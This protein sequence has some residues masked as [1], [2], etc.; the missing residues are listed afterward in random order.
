MASLVS[1]LETEFTPAVGDFII[2]VTGV[3]ATLL[4]KNSS[5]TAFAVVEAGIVGAKICSNP[6][7]AAVYKFQAHGAATVQADQ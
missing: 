6:I 5:G 2:S 7:A 1:A 3:P 4:R